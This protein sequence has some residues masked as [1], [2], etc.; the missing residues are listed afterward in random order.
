MHHPGIL[1]LLRGEADAGK[2]K[3]GRVLIQATKSGE[4]P[5]M[6]G[7]VSVCDTEASVSNIFKRKLMKRHWGL[8]GGSRW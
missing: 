2:A 4:D 1:P 6:L 8:K 5:A 7:E 3:D